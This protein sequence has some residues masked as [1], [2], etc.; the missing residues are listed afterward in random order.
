MRFIGGGGGGGGGECVSV[1]HKIC[2]IALALHKV[3]RATLAKS[4]S[5][6]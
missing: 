6:M 3:C 5:I 2:T 4:T 1:G